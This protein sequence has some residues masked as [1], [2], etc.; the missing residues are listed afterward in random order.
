MEA[1]ICT[2][3]D[4]AHD[5]S[6][7][8]SEIDD[9]MCAVSGIYQGTFRNERVANKHLFCS[10]DIYIRGALRDPKKVD[11]ELNKIKTLFR[12]GEE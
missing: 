5:D 3:W 9:S 8:A 4:I 12:L 6:L 2:A 7:L 1:A 11:I 10:F